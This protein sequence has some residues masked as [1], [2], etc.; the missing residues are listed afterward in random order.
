MIRTVK[1]DAKKVGTKSLLLSFAYAA[2][3]ESQAIRAIP[4]VTGETFPSSKSPG[5]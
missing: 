5:T 2:F 3:H 1:N 4:V